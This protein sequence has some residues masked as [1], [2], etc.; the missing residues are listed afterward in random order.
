MTGHA[1]KKNSKCPLDKQICELSAHI[2]VAKATKK[3]LMLHLRGWGA[4]EAYLAIQDNDVVCTI[5]HSCCWE[6][7]LV[8]MFL[9]RPNH[10]ISVNSIL[11]RTHREAKLMR[12]AASL[13]PLSQ[14]LIESD[15]PKI[16]VKNPSTKK[17]EGASPGCLMTTLKCLHSLRIEQKLT[18]EE[19]ATQIEDNFIKIASLSLSVSCDIATIHIDLNVTCILLSSINCRNLIL[20]QW[21]RFQ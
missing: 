3:P 20:K 6:W 5:L 8:K 11:T 7:P 4:L 19:L 18:L 13:A 15:G 12:D 2:D 21:K 1:S 9:N 14:I 10:Y 17:L 16:L